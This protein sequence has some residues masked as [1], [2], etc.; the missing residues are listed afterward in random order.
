M[1]Q[2]DFDRTRSRLYIKSEFRCKDLN[3]D[4]LQPSE[5]LVV[6]HMALLIA[7]LFALMSGGPSF[8]DKVAPCSILISLVFLAAEPVTVS[9]AMSIYWHTVAARA[10]LR[11]TRGKERPQCPRCHNLGHSYPCHQLRL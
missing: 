10:T 8:T 3:P 5:H 6:S 1:L 4:K 7:L 2:F 9:G 11:E